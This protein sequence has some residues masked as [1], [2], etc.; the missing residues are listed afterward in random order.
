MKLKGKD[1]LNFELANLHLGSGKHDLFSECWSL[2]IF[3]VFVSL[4]YTVTNY[5]FLYSFPSSFI[6][7]KT[8]FVGCQRIYLTTL[9]T[10]DSFNFNL[11]PTW[12]DWKRLH[13]LY[14]SPP[15]WISIFLL[16]KDGYLWPRASGY[17]ATWMWFLGAA[18]L[19]IFEYNI[20]VLQHP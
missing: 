17:T 20:I 10:A 4:L 8:N 2:F 15:I 9:I 1:L 6:S 13:V 19:F 16:Q 5:V 3:L 14:C 7:W 12:I 18:Y 11:Y